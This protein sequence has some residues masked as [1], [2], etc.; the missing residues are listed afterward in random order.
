MA[1]ANFI[2]GVEHQKTSTPSANELS[3][4]R[5]MRQGVIVPFVDFG[6][7]NAGTPDFFLLPM[8]VHQV[9]EFRHVA[10]FERSLRRERNLLDEM[11]ILGHLGV[12][13]PAFVVL[14]FQNLGSGAR[15]AGEEQQEI[16]FEIE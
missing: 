13:L 14:L 3:A 2:V 12:G 7:R 4:E 16:V 9:G 15:V 10:V 5:A 8:H 11:Q 1:Q 6:I